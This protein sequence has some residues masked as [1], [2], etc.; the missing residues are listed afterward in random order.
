MSYLS[1]R[2]SAAMWARVL[3]LWLTLAIAALLVGAFAIGM[4][5][6]IRSNIRAELTSQQISFPAAEALTE[7]EREIPG[8][9][10]NAGLP[11]ETGN[12]AKVYSEYILLHMMEGAEE[13]GYPGA[14]YATLG[15]PQRELRAEIAAAREA[16]DEEAAAEA[17]ARL[18][19]VT[20][21]RNTMLTGSTLRGNLLS[22]FGWDNVGVGVIAAGALI[23][24]LSL[25]FFL[26][27]VFE[28]RRGHLPPTQP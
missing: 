4:G 11:L 20:Q 3:I 24:V 17:Q 2:L 6:F 14:S 26:L 28:R 7:R 15:G 25:V 10:A 21:L 16:N 1:H 8:M 27:F 19:T 13:A 23:C 9:V 18:D 12:Q 22:A 5:L